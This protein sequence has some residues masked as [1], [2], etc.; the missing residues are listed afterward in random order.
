[1]AETENLS[2]SQLWTTWIRRN[3]TV[4]SDRAAWD[5][6]FPTIAGEIAGLNRHQRIESQFV[7]DHTVFTVDDLSAMTDEAVAALRSAGFMH[8]GKWNAPVGSAALDFVDRF[9]LADTVSRL[10]GVEVEEPQGATYIAY[11]EAGGH[12][13]FHLDDFHYGE[14]NLIVCL[15][16]SGT[17]PAGQSSATVFIERAGYRLCPL[18]PGDFIV[19]DG[20]FT[21][22]GRTPVTDG[23]QVVLVSFSFK[24]RS[25]AL[26]DVAD[27]PPAPGTRREEPHT[28]AGG[29]HAH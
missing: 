27:A 4:R 18:Q 13:D 1:M 15:R 8:N 5:R 22:H 16:H 25:R 2:W 29:S 23:E 21:P 24:T 10:T 12:L 17:A 20:A 11:L 7:T 14:V 26:W 28:W 19:F 9:D 6:T 3:T